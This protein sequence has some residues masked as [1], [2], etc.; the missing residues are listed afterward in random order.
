MQL[1]HYIL[2][3]LTV[4]LLVII[5]LWAG[6]FYFTVIDEVND[7]TDDSLENFRGILIRQMVL[8]ST[9]LESRSQDI[10]TK[11]FVTEISEQQAKRYKEHFTDSVMFIEEELEFDPVRVLNTVFRTDNGKYYELKVMTSILEKDD[12]R[13]AIFYLVLGLYLTLLITILL[14]AKIVFARSVRP[15]YK[16]LKWLD[17][18]TL[19]K[20]NEPLD[21]PTKV[22]EFAMLNETIRQMTLKNENI[23]VQQKEF[24]ENA[25]HELQT[26]LAI[27][28]NKLELLADSSDFTEQQFEVITDIHNTMDRAIRLNKTL[29]LLSRIENRQFQEEKKV[30]FNPVVK[31]LLDDL[32][33]VYESKELEVTLEEEEQLNFTMN[34]GLAMTIVSNLLKNAY[35]HSHQNGTIRVKITSGQFSVSNSSG[36]QA[37][38]ENK[39]FDRF[40]HNPDK[41]ESC[42]LGLA[43]VQSIAS[44]YRIKIVYNFDGLHHFILLFPNLS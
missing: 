19:G 4:V 26:P 2:R 31:E 16:L 13:E 42:G 44:L 34:E 21:N 15:L 12:L 14:V 22:K 7:E 8:D 35:F 29:L 28:R 27:C 41:K 25:S 38:D 43:I 9:L 40:H 17:G 33:D 37:L 3:N 20:T 18:F 11:Y 1:I 36:T 5:T 30:W 23:F 10:M 32:N 24:I 6:L 39:I